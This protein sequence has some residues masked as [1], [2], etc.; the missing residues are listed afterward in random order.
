MESTLT[1]GKSTCSTEYMT[2]YRPITFTSNLSIEGLQD[3]FAISKGGS[4]EEIYDALAIEY[5]SMLK[6]ALNEAMKIDFPGAC[7]VTIKRK[8][9]LELKIQDEPVR[10]L[11]HNV[12]STD[13]VTI[14]K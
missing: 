14:K 6:R 13:E 11:F 1:I 7:S 5:K 9:H 3:M 2:P 10:G 8:S 4:D 12:V